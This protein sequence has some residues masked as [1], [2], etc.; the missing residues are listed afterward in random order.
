[1][2]A[3]SSGRPGVASVSAWQWCAR[4][5]LAAAVVLLVRNLGNY[6]L[7]AVRAVRFAFE[8]DYGEGVVWQQ[9]RLLMSGEGYGPIDGFPAIVFHYPPVFHWLTAL[10][11]SCTGGDELATGRGLS[12]TS[13]V[14]VAVVVAAI[15]ARL[16]REG[17]GRAAGVIG[18]SLAAMTVFTFLPVQIW[19]YLMR[20]DMLSFAFGFLGFYVGLISLTRPKAVH[21]AALLFV[22]AI[23]TKQTA[24]AAPASVFLVLLFLRP[25]TAWWGIATAAGA[26]LAILVMLQGLTGG[27]FLSHIVLYNINRFEPRGLGAILHTLEIHSI[28]LGAA[29]YSIVLWLPRLSFGDSARGRRATLRERLWAKPESAGRLMALVYL[30]LT[31]AMLTLALK[32]GAYVNYFIEWCCIVA[33]FVGF[34]LSEATT[35]ALGKQPPQETDRLLALLPLAVAVQTALLAGHATARMAPSLE[36]GNESARLAEL[37]R[38]APRPVIS[39]DMIAVLRGGKPVVWEPAIFAELG[40]R[41]TWDQRPFIEMIKGQQFAFFV[42]DGKPGDPLYDTRHNPRVSEAMIATYP[43]ERQLAGYSLRFPAGKMPSYASSLR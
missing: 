30:V 36:K 14:V 33:I 22:A 16:S 4:F 8:L 2:S 17:S 1:M 15:V 23:Y 42:T 34:M 27:G 5:T 10:L 31:T 43:V 25:R 18:G 38:A 3:I 12:I 29:L 21:A 28:Y 26:G 6:A 35:L 9:M 32:S 19:S 11:S 24:V 20:V 7:A 41:G 13:T 39:D 37:I 40:S